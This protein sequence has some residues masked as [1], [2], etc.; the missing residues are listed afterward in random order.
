MKEYTIYKGCYAGYFLMIGYT[1][2]GT[3]VEIEGIRSHSR[4]IVDKKTFASLFK[5]VGTQVANPAI[6]G[7][8]CDEEVD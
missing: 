6:V 5:Y 8:T 3:S 4:I 1:Q 7:V 2:D